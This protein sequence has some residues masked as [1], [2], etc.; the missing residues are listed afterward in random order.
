M[1]STMVGM[2]AHGGILPVGGTFFVFLDYMR[3]PVRLASLSRMKVCFIYTHDSVGVGEDGPT[4]QPIEQLATL[5]AIPGIHVIR[6]ADANETSQ[7]WRDAVELDGPS[8]LALSRQNIEG[9]AYGSAVASGA[10]VVRDVSGG[11]ADIVIVG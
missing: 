2:A 11:S 3:P 7:A 9:V 4:P 10:G 1:G 5:R 6:P 8:V